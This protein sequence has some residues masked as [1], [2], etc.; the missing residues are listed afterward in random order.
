MVGN[1]FHSEGYFKLDMLQRLFICSSKDFC[2]SVKNVYLPGSM[3]AL[4]KKGRR[5]IMPINDVTFMAFSGS[6]R[7]VGR[8]EI[9]SWQK[10]THPTRDIL[11]IFQEGV[12]DS[13]YA[14]C[15]IP[16]SQRLDLSNEVLLIP[17][18]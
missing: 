8:K 10:S 3:F 7:R 12:V 1:F 14:D 15:L 17:I 6:F 5:S 13:R 9:Q 11:G 2:I 16:K 4:T 18:L